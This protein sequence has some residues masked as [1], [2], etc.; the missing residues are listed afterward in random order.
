MV[1]GKSLLGK[2]SE[3]IIKIL[4]K[5]YFVR[6]FQRRYQINLKVSG[7]C[8]NSE[9]KRQIDDK[10]TKEWLPCRLRTAG[11]KSFK[12]RLVS[13]RSTKVASLTTGPGSSYRNIS[14]CQR[15]RDGHECFILFTYINH[16]LWKVGFCF[17]V[18]DWVLWSQFLEKLVFHV[19]C[20]FDSLDCSKEINYSRKL[21]FYW[22]VV[23]SP[24]IW[25]QSSKLG[26]I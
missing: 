23:T 10:M 11:K 14:G 22:N 19:W 5:I 1:R 3:K 15:E 8:S 4:K 25:S 18:L 6:C 12:T 21:L 9:Y 2:W 7:K 24:C 17:K 16:S 26:Q 13:A 20:L